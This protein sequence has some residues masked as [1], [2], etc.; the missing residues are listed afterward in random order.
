M[1][2]IFSKWNYSQ[3]SAKFT[4]FWSIRIVMKLYSDYTARPDLSPCVVQKKKKNNCARKTFD[5]LVP[6]P[7]KP[8]CTSITITQVQAFSQKF[9]FG[10]NKGVSVHYMAQSNRRNSKIS[11]KITT[12]NGEYQTP[13]LGGGVGVYYGMGVLSQPEDVTPAGC[14][15]IPA[16]VTIDPCMHAW[17]VMCCF[18]LTQ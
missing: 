13:P 5:N 9:A 4:A 6:I 7:E 3:I 15:K 1:G 2:L 18:Y 8:I 17:N 11:Q 12:I 14:K 10:G 16:Q